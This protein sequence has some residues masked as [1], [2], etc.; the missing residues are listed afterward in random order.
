MTAGAQGATAAPAGVSAARAAGA[1]LLLALLIA[2]YSRTAIALWGV[3]TTNDNYSHGPLVPLVSLA[4][5]WMRRHRIA[6][7]PAAGDGRG[8][9]L[10]GLACALQLAGIRSDVLMLQG[11]SFV[12]MLFGLALAFLGTARTRVLAL[13]IG[14]LVFM[15]TF[16]PLLVNQVS[17][18]LKDIAVGLATRAAEM[19]G[20]EL[21]RSGMSLFVASGELRVEHPCSGLRSLIALLGLGALLAAHL[22][23]TWWRR[24]L[25]FLAA[26]PVAIAV[27]AMRITLLILVAHYAGIARV[28]RTLHDVSG[29][30]LYVV[31]LFAMFAVRAALEPGPP[32]RIARS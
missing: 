13:P 11:D 2:I 22:R 18:G 19:L 32:G 31:A 14:Y 10:V 15:L 29:V 16:P 8:V 3:W 12:L 9:A 24:G 21:Q 28:T 30:L 20:V 26:V 25:L 23:G 27:N 7:A 1:T 6:A 5:V 4:L 17:F